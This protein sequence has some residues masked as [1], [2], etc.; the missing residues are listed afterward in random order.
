[1]GPARQ[2]QD[3]IRLLETELAAKRAEMVR[4]RSSSSSNRTGFTLVLTLFPACLACSLLLWPQDAFADSEA[5]LAAEKCV[6]SA[7]AWP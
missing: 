7:H 2:Y 1:M 4:A 5:Q 3:Q 6:R